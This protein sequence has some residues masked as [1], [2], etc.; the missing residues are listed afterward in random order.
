MWFRVAAWFDLIWLASSW[1]FTRLTVPPSWITDCFVDPWNSYLKCRITLVYPGCCACSSFSTGGR[2][3]KKGRVRSWRRKENERE[4]KE[5]EVRR[6]EEKTWSSAAGKRPFLELWNEFLWRFFKGHSLTVKL[7][8]TL[9]LKST[10]CQFR[11]YLVN[12]VNY[13]TLI[14]WLIRD[15]WIKRLEIFQFCKRES[16][17]T[18]DCV[19][20]YLH[21]HLRNLPKIKR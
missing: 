13:N 20:I 4:R 15:A 6:R 9:H 18:V 17:K 3:T 21:K 11:V 2:S 1:F 7:W 19:L 16:C 12:I 14:P 10:I 8:N 5:Q